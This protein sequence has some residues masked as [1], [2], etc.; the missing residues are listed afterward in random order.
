[1]MR[2]LC[3]AAFSIVEAMSR[4]GR[5]AVFMV[6]AA[7]G[8]ILLFSWWPDRWAVVMLVYVLAVYLLGFM[9]WIGRT[10]GT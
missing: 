4:P 6:A 3:R 2:R 9:A 5:W 1:M 8:W 10:H 7:V